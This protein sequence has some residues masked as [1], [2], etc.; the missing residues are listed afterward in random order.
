[1]KS[2]VAKLADYDPIDGQ[3]QWAGVDDTYFGMVRVPP[4]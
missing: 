1:M 2:P 3:V 4:R